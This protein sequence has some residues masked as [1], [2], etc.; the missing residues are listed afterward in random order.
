[1]VER[2]RGSSGFRYLRQ[3]MCGPL[4]RKAPLDTAALLIAK[5]LLSRRRRMFVPGWQ[6]WV[7]VR[8]CALHRRPTKRDAAATA[9][10]MEALYLQNSQQ[11][12]LPVRP[13]APIDARARAG[14]VHANEAAAA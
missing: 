5:G 9:P 12:R 13:R 6:R 7:F 2:T 8:R 3:S 11:S 14:F 4:G 10:E 1:M